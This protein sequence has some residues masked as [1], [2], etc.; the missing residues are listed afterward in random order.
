ML[1]TAENFIE[2]L[3]KINWKYREP[4]TLENGKVVVSCGING[5]NTH[6]D[7]HF[8]FDE[9]GKA[10]CIRVFELLRV[11]IDKKLPVMDLINQLH[12][13]YRWVKFFINTE[14]YVNLQADAII[15]AENSGKVCLELMAHF[16]KIIDESYP[17]FMKIIWSDA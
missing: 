3:K 1:G 8:F 12:A 17:R 10:A 14:E 6:Y 2:E 15:T 16:F 11:P 5:K 7:L 13:Q 4:Q 9:N